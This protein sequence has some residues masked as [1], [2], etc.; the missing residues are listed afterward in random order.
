[1]TY[2]TAIA[3]AVVKMGSKA[4]GSFVKE[5]SPKGDV[6]EAARIAGVMAAKKT[7]DIIPFCHPLPI[8]KVQL[9]FNVDQKEKSVTVIAEISCQGRTGVEME[10]LS[11]VTV[12]ALT[13]YDM[14]KWADKGMMI[15]DV[16]LL[17]KSGGKSGD[18]KSPGIAAVRAKPRKRT[19]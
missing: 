17:A 19:A 10:A 7:P 8:N 11:A 1:M 15:S 16:K 3:S 14:M 13:I 5:G 12:A 4:F 18:Y 6:L 9:R 2:R